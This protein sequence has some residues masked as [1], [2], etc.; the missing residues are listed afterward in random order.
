VR[1]RRARLG[2]RKSDSEQRE[3]RRWVQLTRHVDRVD[4]VAFE[5]ATRLM[6]AIGEPTRAAAIEGLLAEGLTAL[7]NRADL[8]PDLVKTVAGSASPS[9]D[10][11]GS[12]PSD[13]L[14][15]R[16]KMQA[17]ESVQAIEDL[18][19]STSP[20]ADLVLPIAPPISTRR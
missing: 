3:R 5:G 20:E 16:E 15:A 17:G 7:L 1:E 13:H 9:R 2:G 18:Q 14:A 4:A 12:W 10:A 6:E 19:S 11:I 8:A